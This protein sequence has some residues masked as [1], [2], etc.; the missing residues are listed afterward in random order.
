MMVCGFDKAGALARPRIASKS[1]TVLRL[2]VAVAPVS[3]SRVPRLATMP[4]TA[5]AGRLQESPNKTRENVSIIT[6]VED[7]LYIGEFIP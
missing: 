2:A 1:I 4:K 7:H 3:Q 6:P 5:L